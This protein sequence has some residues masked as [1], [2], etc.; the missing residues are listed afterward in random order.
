MR[1]PDGYYVEF[2]TAEGL[3]RFLLDKLDESESVIHNY[4]AL[5]KAAQFGNK[6]SSKAKDGVLDEQSSHLIQSEVSTKNVN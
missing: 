5:M 4:N 3:E 1:D 6:L 2:A